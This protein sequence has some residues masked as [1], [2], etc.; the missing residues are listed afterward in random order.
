MVELGASYWILNMLPISGEEGRFEVA[1][2]C[3]DEYFSAVVV[4]I[5]AAALH[6]M[7]CPL[8]KDDT[9]TRFDGVSRMVACI[10]IDT[11]EGFVGLGDRVDRGDKYLQVLPH[12]FDKGS[13]GGDDERFVAIPIG[14]EPLFGVVGDDLVEESQALFGEAVECHRFAFLYSQGAPLRVIRV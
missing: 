13:V 2:T 11:K 9:D 14:I 8:P 4:H 7:S 1:Y 10:P 6:P 12:L 3:G 5:E